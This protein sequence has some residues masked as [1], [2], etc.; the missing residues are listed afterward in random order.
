M[1]RRNVWTTRLRTVVP[2]ELSTPLRVTR[3]GARAL[4]VDDDGLLLLIRRNRSGLPEENAKA[5]LLEVGLTP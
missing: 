3:R 4:V 5:L 1:T 2:D